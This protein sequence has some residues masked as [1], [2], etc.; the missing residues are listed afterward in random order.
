M[1]KRLQ[2]TL[3][4]LL[5]ALAFGTIRPVEGRSGGFIIE[6]AD[7]T[8]TLSFTSSAELTTLISQV[9]PR[10]VMEFANTNCY[11]TLTPIPTA[12]D[13]LLDTLQSRFVMEF[14]NANKVYTLM[15]IPGQL[16][17]FLGQIAPRFILQYANANRELELNFPVGLIDDSTPPQGSAIEVETAGESSTTISWTTD[18]FADSTVQYGTQSGAYTMISSDPLYVKQH[19]VT[20]TGLT[21]ETTYY[22]KVSSTDLSGNTYQSQEFSFE[23]VDEYGSYWVY[24]PLILRDYPPS[25]STPTPT[26]TSTSPTHTP[27]PTPTLTSTP[28]P[29]PTPT[30]GPCVEA[31]ANGGF[32][33]DGDW[34]L[35]VIGGYTTTVTHDGDRSMLLGIVDPADNIYTYAS[36]QQEV[37]IPTEATSAT[38]RLWLY[39]M[40]E[41]PGDSLPSP[42]LL[43]A[44]PEA[45]LANDVQYVIIRDENDELIDT[46]LWQRSDDR[47]W[48]FHEFDLTAYAGQTIKL[49]FGVYNDGFDGITA[50]YLDDVS[51]EICYP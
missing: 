9:A 7:A 36:A 48:T 1:M 3:L 14:A 35:P 28:T 43:F 6:Y 24:L 19:N 32:E 23:Q 15:P 46:L 8:N 29:T 20:L 47:E 4:L 22:C 11:Y 18:E 10:F 2:I 42:A 5:V 41:E 40:S 12:L 44:L 30:S 31:I 26:S 39:T 38:L 27:T 34:E 16:N 49:N 37:T 50:M 45:A 51:L 33:Y 21:S 17:T 13:D 25:T